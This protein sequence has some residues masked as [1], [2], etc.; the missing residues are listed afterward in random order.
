M[1]QECVDRKAHG[2]DNYHFQ[3]KFQHSPYH[4]NATHSE[5]VDTEDRFRLSA[6]LALQP[7][8][9]ANEQR[10]QVTRTSSPFGRHSVMIFAPHITDEN[11]MTTGAQLCGCR[12]N[13]R[14]TSS[15]LSEKEYHFIVR[16]SQDPLHRRLGRLL[17]RS[18]N[19]RVP[20]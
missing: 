9:A 1:A 2:G 6:Q 15:V 17:H 12:D 13:D 8:S 7:H 10:R 5:F 3:M 4:E 16:D 20:P 18:D 11:W 14:R 19:I